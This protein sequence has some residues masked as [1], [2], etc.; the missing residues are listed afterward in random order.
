MYYIIY[1]RTDFDGICSAKIVEK[2]L[3]EKEKTE[4][5]IEFIGWDYGDPLPI[6][7]VNKEN[8]DEVIVVDLSM[9]VEF[10][11]RLIEL[12]VLTWIDHHYSAIEKMKE[13]PGIENV[14]GMRA[15]GKGA[16]EL[17]WDY[18]FD[19]DKLPKTVKLISLFDVWNHKHEVYDWDR[20]IEP[21]YY[22]LKAISS[23]VDD[24]PKDLLGSLYEQ[25]D[26]E[27]ITQKGREILNYEQSMY[28][29]YNQF[30]FEVEIDGFKLLALNSAHRGSAVLVPVFNSDE[31]DGMIIF[32]YDGKAKQWKHGVYTP[33]EDIDLSS[34]AIKRGGGGHKM[35]AGFETDDLLPELKKIMI[36]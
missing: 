20:A 7:D 19:E 8:G 30:A 5:V 31:Q 11:Q 24:F 6:L 18:Y 26:V 14:L 2:Y 23:S 12:N 21:F 1:H 10:M 3:I 34:I 22:G 35:A 17:C 36:K 25:D 28:P 15:I 9:T 4:E 33:K 27:E 29:E 32:K 16:C 13:I